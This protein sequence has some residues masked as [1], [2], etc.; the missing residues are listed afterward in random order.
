MFL[1]FSYSPITIK[2]PDAMFSVWQ[3][4]Q[5]KGENVQNTIIKPMT[6]DREHLVEGPGIEMRLK[7]QKGKQR[8]GRKI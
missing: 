2:S 5:N 6:R 7:K 8:S 1:I 3:I 4:K